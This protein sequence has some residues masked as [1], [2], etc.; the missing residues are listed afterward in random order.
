MNTGSSDVGFYMAVSKNN[1]IEQSDIE[2]IAADLNFTPVTKKNLQ[3]QY[4][5]NG[6]L[7]SMPALSYMQNQVLQPVTTY[8]SDGFETTRM[9][10]P[11][12]II[13]S[14]PSRENYVIDAAKFSKLYI[15]TVGQT[16]TPE[17][18]PRLVAQYNGTTAVNFIASWGEA[19]AIK[20]G[21]FLV[22][23]NNSYYRIANAEF[24]QTYNMP[25]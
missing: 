6:Q 18:S 22:N 4:V 9:A 15:G 10:Q 21:D 24:Q 13:M 20:P 8:T 16:V 14:G 11:G 12:D 25:S 7:G 3:Y 5:E 19:M 2:K 17:Q 23:D 1:S